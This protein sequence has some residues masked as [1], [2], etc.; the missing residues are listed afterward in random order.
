MIV[1]SVHKK[2]DGRK[3]HRFDADQELLT[4]LNSDP[5]GF[6]QAVDVI[7]MFPGEL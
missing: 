5:S 4:S 7:C 1:P 3:A 6:T 2:N